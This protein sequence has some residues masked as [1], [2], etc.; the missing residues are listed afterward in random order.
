[1]V[2]K[3]YFRSRSDCCQRR[4]SLEETNNS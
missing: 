2:N 3:R 1:V 4:F